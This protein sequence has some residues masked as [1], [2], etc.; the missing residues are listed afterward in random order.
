MTR[1]SRWPVELGVLVALLLFLGGCGTGLIGRLVGP[2]ELSDNYAL[3]PGTVAE[4]HWQTEVHPAPELIDG[5]PETVAVTSREIYIRLPVER[6]L[7]QLVIRNANFEDV[8]VYAGGKSEG[9]WKI[10][11]RVKQNREPTLVIPIRATTDRIRLRIGN[12]H[13]DRFGSNQRR[14]IEQGGVQRTTAFQP[15]QPRAGEIEL[16]GLRRP[17]EAEELLF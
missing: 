7:H 2:Q 15:G 1:S 13:D 11:A 8:I 9:E 6:S 16:Y 3:L 4:W 17:A 12:T 5:D 14:W 10:V